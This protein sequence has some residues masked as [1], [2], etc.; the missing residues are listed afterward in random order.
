V[1]R[2]LR[3]YAALEAFVG[4]FALLSLPLLRGLPESYA[5]VGVP[6]SAFG[7][8][9]LRIAAAAL[10]L[11]PPTLAMGATLP[12]VARGF[13]VRDQ[14]LGRACAQLY[15]ANTFGAVLGAYACGFWLIPELGLARSVLAA[16]RSTWRSARASSRSAATCAS[17]S[18]RRSRALGARPRS[19]RGPSSSCSSSRCRASS[20]SGTRSSG[21]RSSAS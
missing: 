12:V 11:L 21:P 18:R 13:V 9:A 15:S 3:V 1:Q 17:P 5:F 7:L 6:E 19:S 4:A 16:A 8:G 2:P 14:S 10:L 20:R